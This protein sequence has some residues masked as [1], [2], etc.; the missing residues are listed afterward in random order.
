MKKTFLASMKSKRVSQPEGIFTCDVNGCV[1][2][3]QLQQAYIDSFPAGIPEMIRE[4]GDAK[5][6]L[7]EI[8]G[9]C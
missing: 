4:D 3:A 1:T 2:D 5:I 6:R 7:E 8:K 9:S